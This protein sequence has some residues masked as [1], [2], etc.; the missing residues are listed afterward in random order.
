MNPAE[1]MHAAGAGE[2]N[3][4]N[5]NLNNLLTIIA[6]LAGF[7]G[8]AGAWFVLPYRVKCL[9]NKLNEELVTSNLKCDKICFRSATVYLGADIS[10][11][12]QPH[13]PKED[14]A[15]VGTEMSGQQPLPSCRTSNL[16]PPVIRGLPGEQAEEVDLGFQRRRSCG[17]PRAQP[18][19]AAF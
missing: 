16:N 17:Q 8:L 4:V 1:V 11:P 13:T 7:F 9:E 12:M 3:L 15:C 5:L 18:L 2:G 6:C 19:V 14:G 10:V